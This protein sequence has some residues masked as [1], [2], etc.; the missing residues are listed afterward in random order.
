MMRARYG[1]SNIIPDYSL[2]LNKENSTSFRDEGT[3]WRKELLQYC[4]RQPRAVE[5]AEQNLT[6]EGHCA[7]P[8]AHKAM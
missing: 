5:I 3:E 6:A 4:S 1:A 8:A 2:G 7:A